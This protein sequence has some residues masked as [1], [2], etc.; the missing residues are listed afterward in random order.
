MR[1]DSE[2]VCVVNVIESFSCTS[3]VVAGVSL[4]V[5][6]P[7]GSVPS[8]YNLFCVDCWGSHCI[9]CRAD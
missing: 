2:L 7:Q 4:V 9:V 3:W 5:V 1:G 8:R 6:R